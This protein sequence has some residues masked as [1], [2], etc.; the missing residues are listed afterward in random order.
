MK[1]S[2][3]VLLLSLAFLQFITAAAQEQ[4]PPP[5]KL[6]LQIFFKQSQIPLYVTADRPVASFYSSLPRIPSWR[7]PEGVPPVHRIEVS[8]HRVGDYVFVRVSIGRGDKFRITSELVGEYKARLDE[9]VVVNE[10]TKF[11]FEPFRFK[12]VRRHR[13]ELPEIGVA[14]LTRS[15]KVM[16]AE[17]MDKE[18]VGVKVVL[19]NLSSKKVMGLELHILRGGRSVNILPTLGI[20]GRALI[21]PGGEY[22]NF[23]GSGG[24]GEEVAGGY[25][26]LM[27]ETFKVA[28]V[29]FADGSYEGEVVPAA[30]HAASLAGHRHQLIRVLGIIERALAAPDVHTP[31]AIARF[32]TQV[33]E[34]NYEADPSVLEELVASYPGLNEKERETLQSLAA[35]H[36][37]RLQQSVLGSLNDIVSR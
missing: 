23:I 21:E 9:S 2:L 31:E 4:S 34:L 24:S 18:D 15:I 10:L 14:N 5:I 13:V 32:K 7:E 30:W 3:S 1:R 33:S 35:V 37:Y 19:R 25:V 6:S 12:V 29:L 20:N 8:H 26:P 22:K 16:S 11:G 27:P 17:A 36:M 28:S